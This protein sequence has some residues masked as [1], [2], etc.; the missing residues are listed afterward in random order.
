MRRARGQPRAPPEVTSDPAVPRLG[1]GCWR[2][3]DD[4]DRDEARGLSTIHAALDAGVRLL[5]TARAYGLGDRDL[6]HNERLV[7]GALRA[8]PAGSEAIVVTKGGMR[9]PQGGWQADGR[10]RTLLA[11]AAAS[12]EALGRPVVCS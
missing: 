12:A 1:L 5:D 2:L 10:S 9:R 8:H 3:S 4:P 11:D 7:A 6:G